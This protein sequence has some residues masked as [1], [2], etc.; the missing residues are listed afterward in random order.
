MSQKERKKNSYRFRI[1]G[2]DKSNSKRRLGQEEVMLVSMHPLHSALRSERSTNPINQPE[3]VNC[4]RG[5]EGPIKCSCPRSQCV[6][7]RET[8][9]G[10]IFLFGEEGVTSQL[11][12]T[13]DKGSREG[14][15]KRSSAQPFCL[16]SSPSFHS[17]YPWRCDGVSMFLFAFLQCGKEDHGLIWA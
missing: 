11:E 16:C 13:P 10:I 9:E 6:D 2:E 5:R 8:T 15:K 12:C 1:Q 7:S 3:I 17:A 14:N 4:R